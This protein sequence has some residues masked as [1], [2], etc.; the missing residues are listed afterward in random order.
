MNQTEYFT[1]KIATLPEDLQEA[2]HASEYAK[3]LA[4]IQRE[5]KLHIDQGQVLETLGTQ[6]MFGDIDAPGFVNG[7]FNEAHVS[8]AVAGDILLKIDQQILRKIRIYIEQMEDIR[9]KDEELRRLLLE[10]E[11]LA[12]EDEAA[13]YAKYYEDTAAALKEASDELLAKGFSPD[14]SNITD[15]MIARELGI[16][17]EELGK[18]GKVGALKEAQD[19][20]STQS[21]TPS[22]ITEKEELMRELES[23][24]KS[25][26]TPLFKRKEVPVTLPDHQLQNTHVE[27]PYIEEIVPEVTKIVEKPVQEPAP[28]P[29][30][31]VEIPKPVDPTATTIKKPT[32]ITLSIDPYKEPIE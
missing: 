24:E 18:I 22:F 13:V 5:Y 3:I 19:W 26:T 30:P 8:S 7:M 9:A 12:Q 14:G 10:D 31:V 11:E 32:K 23:P 17:V 20:G 2:I 15:D 25:F 28:T 4:D 16:S 6:L 1:E 29:A 27:I 21:F